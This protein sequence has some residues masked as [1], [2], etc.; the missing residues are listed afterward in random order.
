MRSE[1]ESISN[2]YAGVIAD[3]VNDVDYCLR[4]LLKRPVFA[5][6]LVFTLG[7]SIGANI[8]VFTLVNS[9]LVRALPYSHPER[10]VLIS[11]L[12][13]LNFPGSPSS[14]QEWKRD[15]NL[16]EDAALYAVGKANLVGATEPENLQ[17]V[18]VTANFFD[19]LG[20]QPHAGRFFMPD[21]QTDGQDAVAVISEK[22]WRSDFSNDPLALGRTLLLNGRKYTIVGVAQAT[23]N[24]PVGTDVWTPTAHDFGALVASSA[25]SNYLLATLKPGA[26]VIQA[27]AQQRSWMNARLALYEDGRKPTT[28]EPVV[29]SLKDQLIAGVKL[30]TI[31]L[32]AAVVLVLLIGCANV[33]NLILADSAVR[34]HE[35]AVRGA[36]GMSAGRLARQLLTEQLVIALIG[37]VTGLLFAKLTLPYLKTYLP[38]EWPKYAD[39]SIDFR[40]FIFALALSLFVGVAVAIAPCWRFAR[41]LGVMTLAHG[42]RSTEGVGSR[43]WREIVVAIETCLAM[44]LLVAAVLCVRTLRSMTEADLGFKS[45]GVIAATVSRNTGGSEVNR[46]SRIFYSQVLEK[47]GSIPGVESTGGVDYLPARSEYTM[48][49]RIT[50]VPGGSDSETVLATAEAAAPGYFRT[51]RIALVRG[52]DFNE[53]DD[54]TS[55]NVVIINQ[56]LAHKLWRGLDPI[57]RQSSSETFKGPAT[58]IGIA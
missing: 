48:L 10:L 30:S 11:D 39:L 56:V 52:R 15:S 42:S 41:R 1:P 38:A 20:V 44:I 50:P 36:I 17:V 23:C 24:F 51:M 37:G 32:F 43:R 33:A 16:L 25:V 34:E 22:L 35:F 3:T 53:F 31:L 55:G 58:V 5:L 45:R 7:L 8:A 12:S 21:E 47:L 57:G 13:P 54:A 9:L 29:L 6:T 40:V 49:D 46:A 26:T 4:R 19:V 18:S 27:D 2:R 28:S 14:F